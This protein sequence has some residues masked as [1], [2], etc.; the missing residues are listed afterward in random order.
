M[1]WSASENNTQDLHANDS[2]FISK[3]TRMSKKF[4]YTQRKGGD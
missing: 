3:R 1:D 4:K 2:A